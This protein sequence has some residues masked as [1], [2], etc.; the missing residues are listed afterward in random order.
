M[1][2]RMNIICQQAA[3]C[4]ACGKTIHKD[5]D[6]V[7]IRMSAKTTE[8][9]GIYHP[10]CT[11]APDATPHIPVKETKVLTAMADAFDKPEVKA[12]ATALQEAV[13]KL[14]EEGHVRLSIGVNGDQHKTHPDG[15]S[16]G[17][18]TWSKHGY[19]EN[20]LGHEMPTRDSLAHAWQLVEDMLPSCR[21]KHKPPSPV[22]FLRGKLAEHTKALVEAIQ[23]LVKGT[24]YRVVVCITSEDLHR[25]FGVQVF[26][27]SMTNHYPDAGRVLGEA[28]RNH[29][30]S[31]E[32]S[33]VLAQRAERDRAQYQQ[34]EAEARRDRETVEKF[35]AALRPGDLW[36]LDKGLLGI[37]V[38][39][40]CGGVRVLKLD[41]DI[42]HIAIKANK[43]P[44]DRI[45]KVPDFIRSHIVEL[46]PKLAEAGAKNKLFQALKAARKGVEVIVGPYIFSVRK[47]NDLDTIRP[48]GDVF[49]IFGEAHEQVVQR[50]LREI[51]RDLGCD[52]YYDP[53]IRAF[54]HGIGPGPAPKEGNGGTSVEGLLDFLPESIRKHIKRMGL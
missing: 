5:E 48:R 53:Y 8:R 2:E 32:D 38:G 17:F 9:P 24:A 15:V 27:M 25:A 23:P 33:A 16:F 31:M 54:S 13:T 41:G 6:A 49:T 44:Y 40:G 29:L 4:G 1:D 37:I 7:W 22:S 3:T 39:P 42:Q 28:V 26:G 20:G 11:S 50:N 51:M 34:R 19:F 18:Y 47:A 30:R 10:H 36:K 52:G 21:W 14:W 43:L 12:H 45:I 35:I 46:A